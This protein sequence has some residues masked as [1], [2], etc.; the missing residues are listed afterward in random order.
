MAKTHI[1]N[2]ERDELLQRQRRLLSL[3]AH[4]VGQVGACSDVHDAKRVAEQIEQRLN[5]GPLPN[6]IEEADKVISRFGVSPWTKAAL[7]EADNK[8][9]R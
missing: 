3:H 8:E 2:T 6:L 4:G 1:R 7:A 9:G 5:P